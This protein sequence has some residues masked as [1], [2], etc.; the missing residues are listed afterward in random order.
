MASTLNGFSFFFFFF[1]FLKP[2]PQEC[3]KLVQ[4]LSDIADAK[5]DEFQT[6]AATTKEELIQKIGQ[7]M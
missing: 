5:I 6:K 3:E 7:G 2:L 4:Q 1:S